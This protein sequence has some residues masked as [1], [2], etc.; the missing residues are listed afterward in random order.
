MVA[1]D[2][3]EQLTLWDVGSQEVTV[4]F[5]GG[6]VVSDAG[7]LSLRA[8][9]KKLGLIAELAQRL[10]DPRCQKQCTYSCATLLA[11]RV[12][13]IL[14]GYPDG[15]DAQTLRGD[16]LFQTLLDVS[17]DDAERT[18]ASGSTLNRFQYAYTRRQA[19][20]PVEERPVLLEQQAARNERLRIFND[21]LVEVFIRTR[22]ERPKYV[23][24]DLD[25][26][27]DPT[28]G[29]QIL[30]LFH[31]Y[32]EQYQYFPLFAFDGETGLPLAAW[33]RPG[34]VHGSCGAA[35]VLATIIAQLRRAWPGLTILVRGDNGLAV[36]EM[37]EY[38]EREGLLYVLGYATNAVLK[39]DTDAAL[40][41]LQQ[42]WQD[43]SQ[44]DQTW[45]H[46]TVFEDYQAGTWPWPRRLVVKLEVNR[47]GTNR[48]F[49]VTN[50]CGDPQGIY[51]GVYVQRG[52]VPESP[53]G[54]LKK[55]LEADRLSAHGFRA[56]ALL[57]LE[58]VLA[59][60][61][62]V[63]YRQAA[64]AA[65]PEMATAEVSTWRQRLWK[66]GAVVKTSARRIWFHL[67]QSWPF[68]ELWQRLHVAALAWAERVTATA[69][70]QQTAWPEPRPLLSN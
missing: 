46:F 30:S 64:A 21:Y 52:D 47:R 13:Q 20:L 48:R 58:H 50:L 39:R 18:L 26:T 41:V 10:P 60:T 7:L 66:V 4:R 53:I 11:Q 61:L 34:T 51:E 43:A 33:L 1:T 3:V 67:S 28:H 12:Y 62:V 22:T 19:H 16:P 54:E 57:L 32:F 8:F 31:G 65:A 59:Y 9:D 44:P 14:A 15:N 36:P 25:A 42:R 17:P 49:V 24:I 37:Y 6:R 70:A 5:D 55:G 56:N 40:A 27:D 38:C 35:D 29:Q 69:A 45:K 63:L 23:I 2:C 68:A